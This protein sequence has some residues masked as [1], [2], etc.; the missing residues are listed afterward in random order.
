MDF[1]EFYCFFGLFSRL[2]YFFYCFRLLLDFFVVALL[3]FVDFFCQFSNNIFCFF[4][5]WN[6]IPDFVFTKKREFNCLLKWIEM[7]WN[8]N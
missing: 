3:C 5:G 6:W 8:P 2:L 4:F 1:F 7:L